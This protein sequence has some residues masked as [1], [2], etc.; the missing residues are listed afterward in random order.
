MPKIAGALLQH[1][2]E[3]TM[4]ASPGPGLPA[5]V[6]LPSGVVTVAEG[7]EGDAGQLA[8]GAAQ[9]PVG[10]HAVD[11]VWGLAHVLQ[12]QDGAPQGGQMGRAQQ[13]G[14]HGEVG[15]QQGALGHP[16][17]PALPLQGRRRLAEQQLAQSLL[18]PGRLRGQRG[19]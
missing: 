14:G 7:A 10:E 16:A 9:P 17:A 19:E 18:A 12:H 5:A 3:P 2:F 11:A 4:V 8:Q 13:V 6:P 15:H 1:L